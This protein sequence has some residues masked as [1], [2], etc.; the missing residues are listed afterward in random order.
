MQSSWGKEEPST[1]AVEITERVAAL[2]GTDS[3]DLPSLHR[4]VDIEAV[5]RL[6]RTEDTRVEFRYSGH[7][8][9]VADGRVVLDA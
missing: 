5:E 9:V 1:L 7:D 3:T 4:T 6:A 8:V 2:E